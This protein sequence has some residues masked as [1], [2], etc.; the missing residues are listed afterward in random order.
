MA[1]EKPDLR[2]YFVISDGTTPDQCSSL[3][4][5]TYQDCQQRSLTAAWICESECDTTQNDKNIC[6]VLDKFEGSFFSKLREK[7]KSSLIVGPL[8]LRICLLESIEIPIQ[9]SKPFPV[10]SMA[11]RGLHITC[12]QLSPHDKKKIKELVRFMGGQYSNHVHEKCTHVVT[13]S[14]RSPKYY[15]AIEMKVAVMTEEWIY[16]VWKASLTENVLATDEQ[17]LKYKCPIFH[18]L[19]IT[20][21]NLTRT[22]K[23]RLGKIICQNGG[24]YNKQLAEGTTTLLVVGKPEGEKFKHA[25][26]WGL[27]CVTPDWINECI[28]KDFA[29]ETKNFL[30]A[31]NV[32]SSTQLPDQNTNF[33]P[34][35][36]PSITGIGYTE[37]QCT[38]QVVNET[39][40]LSRNSDYRTSQPPAES[41]RTPI[42]T[43][44]KSSAGTPV[45]T[46]MKT[47]VKNPYNYKAIFS[48]LNLHDAKRSSGF[49]DGCKVFLSGFSPS[50]EDLLRKILNAGD[51]VRYSELSDLVTHVV[52]GASLPHLTNTLANLRTKPYVVT[53]DWIKMS[54]QQQHPANEENYLFS[55]ISQPL[56]AASPLAQRGLEMLQPEF[57]KPP[58]PQRSIEGSP[59]SKRI[60]REYSNSSAKP[61]EPDTP[62]KENPIHQ[63]EPINVPDTQESEEG[64][65][66]DLFRGLNF[67]CHNLDSAIEAEVM[68]D[69]IRAGGKIVPP[70]FAGVLDY[71]VTSVLTTELQTTTCEVVTHLWIKDCLDKCK[72]LDIEFYH[73]P[74]IVKTHAKP[75][76]GCV[77]TSSNYVGQVRN[78]IR[79]LGEGLGAKVQEVFAKKNKGDAAASTHLICP[80]S[81]GNKFK[82]SVKWKLPAVTIDWIMS[83]ANSGKMLPVDPYLV[84]VH[85]DSMNKSKGTS[86]KEASPSK[87]PA[88]ASSTERQ[89]AQSNYRKENLADKVSSL[90]DSFRQQNTNDSLNESNRIRSRLVA[91]CDNQN[92]MQSL[93]NMNS[94]DFDPP[95]NSTLNQAHKRKSDSPLENS[96]AESSR[97][98]GRLAT[99]DISKRWKK[100]DEF[101]HDKT[102]EPNQPR[103][104]KRLGA[105]ISEQPTQNYDEAHSSKAPSPESQCS[106]DSYVQKVVNNALQNIDSKLQQVSAAGSFERIKLKKVVVRKLPVDSQ[107]SDQPDVGW[108]DPVEAEQRQQDLLLEKGKI[109]SQA[110]KKKF[111]LTSIPP[112]EKD[113][114]QI[115][116]T[117]LGGTVLIDPLFSA[118]ATHLIMQTP[119]RSEKLLCSMA[120]G[121][122]ILHPRYIQASKETGFF[123]QEEDF[124]WG[125]PKSAKNIPPLTAMSSASAL[126]MAAVRWR[127]KISTTG[128]FAFSG[129]RALLYVSKQKVEPVTRLV[130]NGGGEIL[131]EKELDQVTH[132]FIENPSSMQLN[133]A[134]YAEYH[135]YCLN[136]LF[137]SDFLTAEPTLSPEDKLIQEYVPY[138]N[139]YL[140]STR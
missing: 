9:G 75:L 38:I 25:L 74:Q 6:Y 60:L 81:E 109:S 76:T 73:Q 89:S 31:P 110:I 116:I 94:L 30:I 52:V 118:E 24:R 105:T 102:L 135:I 14:V 108:T 127:K 121:L 50:E 5:L 100:F 43:P 2:I 85:D 83:C 134:K 28:K 128:Q 78:F 136:V 42:K 112:D 29:V 8:C 130:Q 125:N 41:P 13:N 139:S 62:E 48:E 107:L 103:P 68:E 93:A 37:N 21:T 19:E 16:A 26:V 101:N 124:E 120:R 114:L 80:T 67:L 11:M 45:K 96:G 44:E 129:M 34:E 57:R 61:R 55:K 3:M 97:H 22:E 15:K 33:L 99:Q 91:G 72:I 106:D 131:T 10:F 132:C 82:A 4:K 47:P 1:R 126:A 122:W 64:T 119:I 17:F 79:E 36:D 54:I 51:A 56:E 90:A 117:E 66:T 70:R 95:A 46:P 123:L 18:G 113:E 133:W 58:E 63:P 65:I 27:P 35:S 53:L 88:T 23:E 98:S 40:S 69:V 104:A 49:L 115:I 86:K 39:A 92:S 111:I 84:R 32:K 137:L 138:Y 7:K 140:S 12:S 87:G 20:L 77:L 59:M 71:T